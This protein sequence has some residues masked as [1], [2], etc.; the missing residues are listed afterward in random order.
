MIERA[1]KAKLHI[2]RY[3]P[4]TYISGKLFAPVILPLLTSGSRNWVDPRDD[5]DVVP[6]AEN[7]L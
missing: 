1:Q 3:N 2:S 6:N 5:K 7:L 4:S